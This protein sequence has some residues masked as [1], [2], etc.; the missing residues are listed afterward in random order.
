MVD[1]V[2]K[3]YV[4]LILYWEKRLKS[5]DGSKYYLLKT[6]GMAWG[7]KYQELTVNYF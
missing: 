1:Q 5:F 7:T 4:K 3:L 6:E 2:S